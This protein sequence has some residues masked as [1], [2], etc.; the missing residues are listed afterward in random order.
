MQ[1]VPRIEREALILE[2]PQPVVQRGDRGRDPR[3]PH[4]AVGQIRACQ[5][6]GVALAGSVEERAVQP[7]DTAVVRVEDDVRVE[8][9]RRDR[10]LIGV[11]AV[12]EINSGV[13]RA[14]DGTAVRWTVCREDLAVLHGAA[15]I[16]DTRRAWR[17]VHRHVVRTL[18]AAVVVGREAGRALGRAGQRSPADVATVVERRGRDICIVHPVKSSKPVSVGISDVDA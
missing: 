11:S 16:D 5:A 3:Q 12:R 7:P 1:R 18:P 2:R 15:D 4:V 6:A 13:R 14:L 17:R 8:R 10:V 9:H